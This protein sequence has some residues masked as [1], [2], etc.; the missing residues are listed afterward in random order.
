VRGPVERPLRLGKGVGVVGAF[1]ACVG[2]G[3][4]GEGEAELGQQV[5]GIAGVLVQEGGDQEGNSW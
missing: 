3:E 4:E 1:A 5:G 2:R